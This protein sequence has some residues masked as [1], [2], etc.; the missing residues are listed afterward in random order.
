MRGREV[1]Q[2]KHRV[3]A[4]TSAV[5]EVIENTNDLLRFSMALLDSNMAVNRSKNEWS[6]FVSVT[7]QALRHDYELS[8]YE[9]TVISA[10]LNEA[11]S[12]GFSFNNSLY[13]YIYILYPSDCYFE[14]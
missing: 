13:I 2:K 3:I 10:Y 12:F 4:T 9:A 6:L 14:S 11:K 7:S 5:L 1:F 8:I